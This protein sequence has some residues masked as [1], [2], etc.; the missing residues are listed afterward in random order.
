MK[1]RFEAFGRQVSLFLIELH[2]LN[3]IDEETRSDS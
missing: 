3:W 1:R 2:L